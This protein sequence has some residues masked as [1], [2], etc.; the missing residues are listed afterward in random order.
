MSILVQ[1]PQGHVYTAK[2]NSGLEKYAQAYL[3]RHVD[4]Q[5][6]RIDPDACMSCQKE[7]EIQE[8]KSRLGNELKKKIGMR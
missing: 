7:K 3:G 2:E 6:A 1:C 5:I 4:E 8:E